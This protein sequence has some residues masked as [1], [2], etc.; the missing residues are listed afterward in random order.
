MVPYSKWLE[1]LEESARVTDSL[2]ASSLQLL[3]FYQSASK[4]LKSEDDEA[5]GFPRLSTQYA[6]IAVPALSNFE[7]LGLEDVTSWLAYWKSAGVLV[8][9]F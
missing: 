8:S 7:R 4:P 5:F 3:D 2:P 9:N 1:A 6:E